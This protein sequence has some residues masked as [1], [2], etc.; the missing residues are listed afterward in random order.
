MTNR[1]FVVMQPVV[2]MTLD[3]LKKASP[4]GIVSN[5]RKFGVMMIDIIET[6]HQNGFMGGDFNLE[7]FAIGQY[8]QLIMVD[9]SRAAR[10]H[11]SVMDLKQVFRLTAKLGTQDG[12]DYKKTIEKDLKLV[13]AMKFINI[14]GVDTSWTHSRYDEL[15]KILN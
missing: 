3:G 13:A 14:P 9:I 15:R 2:Q 5:A 7:S 6:L 12:A 8:N 11:E 10:N 1:E 4:N